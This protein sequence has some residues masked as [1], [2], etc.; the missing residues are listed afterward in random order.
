MGGL[1][2]LWAAYSGLT[3]VAVGIN[4]VVAP[5]YADRVGP[6]WDAI[7]WFMAPAVLGTLIV[8]TREKLRPAPADGADLRRYAN[9]SV[10]FYAA[11]VMTGLVLLELVH[12][13][14]GHGR[15]RVVDVRE[16][17]VHRRHRLG[18][19]PPVAE[20]PRRLTESRNQPWPGS[21]QRF[22]SLSTL[23][24][25][26]HHSANGTTS[27]QRVS[28]A[29]SARGAVCG[30]DRNR[31]GYRRRPPRHGAHPACSVPTHVDR[32]RGRS[33]GRAG[34]GGAPPAR[35]SSASP[36]SRTS[37]ITPS[38]ASGESATGLRKRVSWSGS[39]RSTA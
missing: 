30:R 6:V 31:Y 29:P 37:A 39:R 36:P 33:V 21:A 17:A 32:F 3:A 9:V 19:G 15:D 24:K 20:L 7:N 10:G 2:R 8:Y 35:R 18:R 28:R 5:F 25:I 16:R 12:G 27:G 14:G 1:G 13:V 26:A 11:L 38:L 22:R 4:V 23:S 34:V